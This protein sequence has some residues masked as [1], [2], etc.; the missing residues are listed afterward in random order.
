MSLLNQVLQDLDGREEAQP[1][2]GLRLAA[3][4]EP[5]DTADDPVGR[6]AGFPM[7]H[8]AWLLV[9][10]LLAGGV[11]LFWPDSGDR[12]AVAV[13][14]MVVP[15]VLP[16][17]VTPAAGP[18]QIPADL[19]A[20]TAPESPAS[21][22]TDPVSEATDTTTDDF[23]PAV[24]TAGLYKEIVV[25]T[26]VRAE[27]GGTVETGADQPEPL[28]LLTLRNVTLPDVPS[29]KVPDSAESRARTVVKSTTAG[30]ALVDLRNKIAGGELAEAEQGLR[31]YLERHPRS[32]EARELLIGLILRGGRE[33][34]AIRELEFGLRHHPD[35]AVFIL[36]RARLQ[37]EAGQT[38]AAIEALESQRQRKR[39]TRGM[40]EML[41][42]LYQQAG[43]YAAATDTYRELLRSTPASGPAWAGLAISLDATGDAEA[44]TAYRRALQAGGLPQAAEDYARARLIELGGG[45]G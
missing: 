14:P 25:E 31:A 28:P 15:L 5:P 21:T 17:I 20:V 9:M 45:N 10:G 23:G 8:L 41:G 44:V 19:F 4:P 36:I 29:T 32:R 3:A 7:R 37:V 27:D 22:E 16:A 12:P 13:D 11:Y 40:L 38:A 33:R 24:P 43:Q 42:A 26:E 18:E 34:A 35:H 1:G 6:F 30:S 39:A 2:P